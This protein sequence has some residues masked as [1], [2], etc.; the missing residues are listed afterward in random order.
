MITRLYN[1]M[2][3]VRDRQRIAIGLS[4][5]AAAMLARHVDLRRPASWEFS[6]FSQNGED[7]ILGVLRDQLKEQNRYFIEI[8][9]ADGIDNNSAWLV[10]TAK[11][12]GIMI[13]GN[14]RLIARAR[15]IV[16]NYS[17]GTECQH[18][19]VT[20]ASAPVLKSLALHH[21]PDVFSLDIDGNDYYVAKAILEVGFRPKIFV[22]EY[23]SVFGPERSVT[24][25][26]RDD[27]VFGDAHASQ[28]YYGVSISGWRRFFAEHGYRFITVD[29]NGVNGFFVDPVHVSQEFLEQ[30]TPLTFAENQYQLGEFRRP[31]ESQFEL[32]SGQPLVTI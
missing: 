20:A 25:P 30:V 9:A 28:L 19:F 6:G 3:D 21:D 22:V 27:F 4:K 8:G 23:N 31:S 5:G 11:Y 16:A 26:Y 12:N 2:L 17:V 32:I 7:G 15:R 14:P 10:M 29:R 13:D 1:Y 24:I 18:M